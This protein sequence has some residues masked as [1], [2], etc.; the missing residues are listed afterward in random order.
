MVGFYL[1]AYFNPGGDFCLL[2]GQQGKQ[3][4]CMLRGSHK[5][6]CVDLLHRR[7]REQ[8]LFFFLRLMWA[9]I[10]RPMFVKSV[11]F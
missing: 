1:F 3:G 10:F 5:V 4:N 6:K 2:E 9:Q 11:Y 7:S 8:Q